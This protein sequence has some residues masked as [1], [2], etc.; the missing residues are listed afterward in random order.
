MVVTGEAGEL[1]PALGKLVGANLLRT[2]VAN[3]HRELLDIVAGGHFDM[4]VLDE[5][6]LGELDIIR[7]LRLIRRMDQ[8]V[9][10]VLVTSHSDRRWLEDAIKLSA[11]SVLGK[12]LELEVLL[13]QLYSVMMR[14]NRYV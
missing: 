11:F 6:A 8:R 13:R 12:P 7:L 14:F 5:E 3:S 9:A 10:V 1:S 4:A 2:T